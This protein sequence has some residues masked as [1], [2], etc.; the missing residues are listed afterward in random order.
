[1]KRQV[2]RQRPMHPG[3]RPTEDVEQQIVAADGRSVPRL[4]PLPLTASAEGPGAD[5]ISPPRSTNA[6]YPV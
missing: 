6:R 1:V 4:Q 5:G 2:I 3:I